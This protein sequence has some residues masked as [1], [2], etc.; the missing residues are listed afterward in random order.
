V[1]SVVDKVALG[2]VF[3][4]YLD[5]SCESPFHQLLHN[6]HHLSFG[7]GTIGRSTKWTQSHPTN[8]R[9][10][11]RSKVGETGKRETEW[12]W[13]YCEVQE[14]QKKEREREN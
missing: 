5:F 14:V 1:A 13:I 2:Q 12:N 9:K 7:V 11:I 4:E 10:I 3:S 8:N 6:H